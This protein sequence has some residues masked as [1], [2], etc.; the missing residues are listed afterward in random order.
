MNLGTHGRLMN[1]PGQEVRSFMN[2]GTHGRLL[3]L[4]GVRSFMN[5]APDQE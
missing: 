5:E 2:L 4:P 1:E 3:N